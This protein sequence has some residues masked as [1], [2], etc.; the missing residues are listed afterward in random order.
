MS[1]ADKDAETAAILKAREEADRATNEAEEAKRQADEEASKQAAA[2]AEREHLDK[3]TRARV[4]AKQQQVELEAANTKIAGESD[5]DIGGSDLATALI[6]EKKAATTAGK[7]AEGGKPPLPVQKNTSY[8]VP[9]AARRA[10]SR[11]PS[12][13]PAAVKK[14]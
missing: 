5:D 14:G 8:Q 11:T 6:A 12:R 7:A 13:A 1:Q 4:F 3:E 9:P 10:P 2:V